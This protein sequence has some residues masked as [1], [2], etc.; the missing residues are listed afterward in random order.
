MSHAGY[1][2]ENIQL[3]LVDSAT[4]ETGRNI[5][6]FKAFALHVYLLLTNADP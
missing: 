6:R 3:G 2:P 5:L 1:N 4:A